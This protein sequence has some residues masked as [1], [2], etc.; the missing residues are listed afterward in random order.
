MR[1]PDY[2][3]VH[4]S[5]DARSLCRR[6]R[7]RV[8]CPL[9]PRLRDVFTG[10]SKCRHGGEVPSA[11]APIFEDR[12]HLGGAGAVAGP[13]AAEYDVELTWSAVEYGYPLGVAGPVAEPPAQ[14]ADD[15]A[16]VCGAV[17]DRDL[18]RL[19]APL[20]VDALERSEQARVPIVTDQ[21][22]QRTNALV[23]R[24]HHVLG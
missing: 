13:H 2:E 1:C 24:P 14:V 10:A 20:V 18:D 9:L 23:A 7:C 17:D 22:H 21:L 19:V 6:P 8:R 5:A 11:W 4:A 3:G 15:C 12:A 16:H